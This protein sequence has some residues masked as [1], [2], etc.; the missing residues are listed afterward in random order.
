MQYIVLDIE[1]IPGD[2]KSPSEII[3]IGAYKVVPEA[4]K[5][6]K[7]DSFNSLVKPLY[8]SKVPKKIMKLTN[9]ETDM[10]KDQKTFDDVIED[11][12][13]WV[14]GPA[15][16]ISWGSNDKKWLRDNCK[17]HYVPSGWLNNF[18]DLQE[19]YADYTK[20]PKVPGLENTALLENIIHDDD[21]VE[22]RALS[23][24]DV[25]SKIFQKMF[26]ELN[27]KYWLN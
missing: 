22:H 10:V 25:C 4:G 2:R 13:K 1:A 20:S 14:D 18:I 7:T 16:F 8:H 12:H 19:M 6:R 11:F 9:I 24:A 15:V 5:L 21:H 23:D 3:E 26:P 27:K 17:L